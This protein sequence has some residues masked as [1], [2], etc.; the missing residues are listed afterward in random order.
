MKRSFGTAAVA[1]VLLAGMAAPA[2]ARTKLPCNDGGGGA[3]LRVK[4]KRCTV[5]PPGASFS[6]GTNLGRLKWSSFG[7]GRA[8]FRGIEK[9]F[10]LPYSKIKV[11]GYAYRPRANR[12]GSSRIYTRVMVK[13]R[14]GTIRVKTQTCVR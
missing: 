13:S 11:T 10:H 3:V 2:Q 4:P 14:F 9:G 5:L 8:R 6:E 1:I 7:G 12:C